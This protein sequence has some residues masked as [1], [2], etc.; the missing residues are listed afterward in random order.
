MSVKFTARLSPVQFGQLITIHG[1]TKNDAT[2]FVEF[3]LTEDANECGARDEIPF[4]LSVRFGGSIVRNSRSAGSWETEE[5][6][7]NLINGNSSN[8]IKPGDNFKIAILI[9]EKMFYVSIDDKPYCTFARRANPLGVKRL[10]VLGDVDQIYGMLQTS[11][12]GKK[13]PETFV[14]NFRTSIPK[15]FQVGD[16]IVIK[17][18]LRG[19]SAGCFCLNILDEELK[20]PFFHARVYL[21]EG[22]V[23]LDS[24]CLNHYWRN[25]TTLHPS[26]FPF[27]IGKEFNITVFVGKDNFSFIVN[28]VVIGNVK[29]DDKVELMFPRL[30]LVELVTRE[31]AFIDVT[32]LTFPVGRSDDER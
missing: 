1:K 11:A 17:G 28:G 4:H 26:N 24:Q 13:W 5:T 20:R 30:N 21:G 12:Q 29:F 19:S 7:E 6:T 9:A 18:V 31:A 25:P 3:E 27:A 15:K 16:S 23:V 2:D 14:T 10:N 22:R 8:P 32:S